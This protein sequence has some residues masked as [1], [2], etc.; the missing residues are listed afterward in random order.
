ML[1]GNAR[2]RA[3]QRSFSAQKQ[4]L[5]SAVKA[6]RA[7]AFDRPTTTALAARQTAP[8]AE[9]WL[10]RA[11]AEVANIRWG[12]SQAS[13]QAA[14]QY[15]RVMQ[16]QA[17]RE[18]AGQYARLKDKR[19]CLEAVRLARLANG[20]RDPGL[21]ELDVVGLLVR[22]GDVAAARSVADSLQNPE[23]R[24]LAMFRIFTTASDVGDL[25]TAREYRRLSRDESTRSESA[26]QRATWRHLDDIFDALNAKNPTEALTIASQLTDTADPTANEAREP[27][28]LP[29]ARSLALRAVATHY[30][31]AKDLVR[32]RDVLS[33]IFDKGERDAAAVG[34]VT[35]YLSQGRIEEAREWTE[36]L[37]TPVSV[38]SAQTAIARELLKQG[39]NEGFRTV[40]R[41]AS[42]AAEVTPPQAQSPALAA[43]AECLADAGEFS[44]ALDI[45]ARITDDDQR[46]QAQSGIATRQARAGRAGPA[47]QTARQIAGEFRRAEA[48]EGLVAE[49]A[50][51]GDVDGALWI[52]AQAE[53]EYNRQRCVQRIATEQVQAG[54]YVEAEETMRRG[55]LVWFQD[56]VYRAA[57]AAQAEAGLVKLA[58]ATAGRIQA[59]HIRGQAYHLVTKTCIGLLPGTDWHTWVAS[60]NSPEERFSV[61]LGVAEGLLDSSGKSAGRQQDDRERPASK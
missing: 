10:D 53:N 48:F 56:E 12:Q 20:G 41:E 49:Q 3:H 6:E 22:C 52:A 13:P 24:K 60:L 19:K 34:L 57:A 14:E 47:A 5:K 16:S 33:Q 26:S 31:Q 42:R 37:A 29:N 39:D 40:M 61:C 32:A 36:G 11:M 43:I 7:A 21:F 2:I 59:D 28:Q 35:G 1:A 50:K 30:V 25:E 18:V 58:Y 4:Y 9:Y 15:A 51:R 46:Y 44:P 55:R 23:T 38:A 27:G 8:T 45:A 17:Y 54:K